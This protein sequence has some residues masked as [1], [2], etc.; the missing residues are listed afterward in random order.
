VPRVS[1]GGVP[2]KR[3]N[4]GKAP[5]FQFYVKD[6]LSD[7]ELQ[8][9]S[10]STRGL[11]ID[12]LCYMWQA[13][14]RGKLSATLE[15][16]AKLLRATNGDLNKFLEDAKRHEFVTV[17]IRDNEVTLINRRMF[18]EYNDKENHRLRQQRYRERQK[19]DTEMTPPSASPS[20]TPT[21]K[22]EHIGIKRK[23]ILT[24]EEWKTEVLKLYP[25]INWNDLNRDIDLWLLTN[26]HRQKTR[27]LITTFITRKIKDKPMQI[28][29]PKIEGDYPK[30]EDVLKR[31]GF[32]EED[33]TWKNSK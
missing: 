15:E 4:V 14:V 24:D 10:A 25:W 11:W 12:A 32:T 18:R 7:P 1:A 5:A 17:T 23:K 8:C 27:S 31:Q 6:W 29:K 22:K 9:V 26:P 21:A 33:F 13:P 2:N 16:M 3:N 19:S 20:P 30:A 28:N